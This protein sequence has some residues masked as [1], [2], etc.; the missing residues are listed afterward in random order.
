VEQNTGNP[1]LLNG[2]EVEAWAVVSPTSIPG[3]TMTS[4]SPTKATLPAFTPTATP[5]VLANLPE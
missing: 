5:P 2:F 3:T 1:A 4:V